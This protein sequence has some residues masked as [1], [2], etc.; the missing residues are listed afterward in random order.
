MIVRSMAGSMDTL[1]DRKMGEEDEPFM[2]ETLPFKFDSGGKN[3]DFLKVE[4]KEHRTVT[5]NGQSGYRFQLGVT[6]LTMVKCNNGAALRQLAKTIASDGLQIQ[7]DG[8][9]SRRTL[10]Y[11]PE[12]DFDSEFDVQKY[13]K[14][15]GFSAPFTR[16][17]AEYSLGS[18]SGLTGIYC[19]DAKIE[20]TFMVDCYGIIAWQQIVSDA[21]LRAYPMGRD[22]R[23][24]NSIIIDSPYLML[25]TDR[26]LG[27]VLGMAFIANPGKSE[28]RKKHDRGIGFGPSTEQPSHNTNN[29]N[30]VQTKPIAPTAYQFQP[31]PAEQTVIDKFVAKYGRDVKAKDKDGMTLLHQAV[32]EEDEDIVL[33]V[34]KFLVSKGADVNAKDWASSTPLH[35]VAV[36]GNLEVAKFLVSQGADVN[37]KDKN[38][39]TPLHDAALRTLKNVRVDKLVEVV[40]FLVAQGAGVNAKG[41]EGQTP[42]HCAAG[43][44]SV[45]IAQFLVSQGADIKAKDNNGDT[46]LHRAVTVWN[47]DDAKVARFFVSQGVD[48]NIRNN[49]GKTPLDLAKERR[50]SGIVEY[51]QSVGTR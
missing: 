24:P 13:A 14:A 32:W 29:I 30:T 48:V 31:T 46:P 18:G 3:T 2:G 21:A 36:L 27:V 35:S 7:Q 11:L 44:G 17:R 39:Y 47:R 1:P 49:D 20:C 26:K 16:G 33:V 28:A 50:F 8:T 5:V 6:D 40:K 41:W 43:S 10:L 51:L 38:S 12:V 15:K 34:A 37:A 45:E 25:L 19:S 23:L 4:V 9:V 22:Q 42:L